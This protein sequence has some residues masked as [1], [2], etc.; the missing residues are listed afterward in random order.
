MR[1]QDQP[2]DLPVPGQVKSIWE[3][4]FQY[5]G[6]EWGIAHRIPDQVLRA[7]HV[8]WEAFQRGSPVVAFSPALGGVGMA[9]LVRNMVGAFREDAVPL[10]V[11]GVPRDFLVGYRNLKDIYQGPF[12]D[13][14]PLVIR[15]A[16]RDEM[17]LVGPRRGHKGIPARKIAWATSKEDTEYWVKNM[18][19]PRLLVVDRYPSKEEAGLSV[20]M[21]SILLQPP[22]VYP[23]PEGITPVRSFVPPSASAERLASQDSTLDSALRM[24]WNASSGKVRWVSVQ[25]EVSE[26]KELDTAYSAL[27]QS[28]W[29]HKEELPSMFGSVFR[30]LQSEAAPYGFSTEDLDELSTEQMVHY[31]ELMHPKSASESDGWEGIFLEMAKGI[32]AKRKEIPPSKGRWVID[33]FSNGVSTSGTVL[34]LGDAC[35][36]NAWNRFRQDVPALREGPLGVPPDLNFSPSAADEVI[37]TSCPTRRDLCSA[38]S[39]GARSTLY[40]L[41][42]WE[43]ERLGRLLTKFENSLRGLYTQPWP[44]ISMPVGWESQ[45]H[46][47]PISSM[48]TPSRVEHMS[49]EEETEPA[50]DGPEELLVRDEGVPLRKFTLTFD[51][52]EG[53][54]VHEGQTVIAR[55]DG[56]FLETKAEDLRPGDTIVVPNGVSS[57]RTHRVL[58]KVCKLRVGWSEHLHEATIW[59]TLLRERVNHDY[60][61][62]TIRRAY[63][64]SGAPCTYD[65]FRLWLKG[66]EPVAPR[67]PNLKWM[68]GWLGLGEA[69]ARH[70]LEMRDIHVRDRRHIYR[71]LLQYNRGRYDQ[72]LLGSEGRDKLSDGGESGQGVPLEEIVKLVSFRTVKGVSSDSHS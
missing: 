55:R 53:S 28:A 12:A 33:H 48:E 64:D 50:G 11:T 19:H 2:V 49:E 71:D 20:P 24:W 8:V 61:G 44:H 45:A 57:V 51:A 65:E 21:V 16:L 15:G 25:S 52:G 29:D 70:T 7:T 41:H 68:Y 36:A 26:L 46:E 4:P 38:V 54:T 5:K 1:E 6:E 13:R 18:E 59:K 9:L 62:Q 63:E 23:R 34:R 72:M 32:L 27:R 39:G 37:V 66:D 40:V 60:S 30:R 22:L 67:E 69:L 42:P 47:T 3:S 56:K 43:V 17:L 35:S 14:C 10:V 58:E 31:L